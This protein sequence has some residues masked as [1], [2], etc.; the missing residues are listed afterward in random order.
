M[1]LTGL[2]ALV[3]PIALLPLFVRPG[4]A[5]ALT[6]LSVLAWLSY[7]SVAYPIALT[8]VP[9]IVFGIFGPNPVPEGAVTIA[10]SAAVLF[11]IAAVV[12]KGGAIPPP[13]VIVGPPLVLTLLLLCLMVLRQPILPD[14]NYG[15]IKT[16]FF[17][18]SNLVLLLGGIFVGWDPRALR[19]LLV[20]TLG[21]A[22]AG[23]IALVLYVAGG[24]TETLL[25]IAVSFSEGDHSISMGRE[26]TAGVLVALALTI[27]RDAGSARLVAVASLP[28]LVTALIASGAR[29]PV[30][31]LIAGAVVLLL[32][33]LQDQLARRRMFAIAT[34][35]I[36]AVGAVQLLVPSASIGRA[37]SFA[38]SD[39]AGTSSGRTEMWS[40]AWDLITAHP[41]LGIGTGGFADVN[42]PM[43]Y[44]HNLLL[45]VGSELGAAGLILIL[46]FL[47]HAF[48]R[49]MRARLRARSEDRVTIAAVIALF[50]AAF[51]NSLLSYAIHANWEV[52]LWAGVGTALAARMLGAPNR[53]G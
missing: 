7:R 12:H 36:V 35:G 28:I 48:W 29:G 19:T 43:I 42:P 40:Q 46:A 23:G 49:M 34:A 10:L 41:L 11:G 14:S 25:P 4:V 5:L 33:G 30:V 16:E 15:T 20:T 27:G 32:L 3:A 52:W 13:A 6:I 50:A 1:W 38:S 2:A 45:E 18:P 21:I 17:V 47:G 26:M 9:A 22:V 51:T 8:G 44:P 31:A 53:S 37:F 39:V 24:G